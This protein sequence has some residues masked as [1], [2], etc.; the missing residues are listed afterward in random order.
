MAVAA[1]GWTGD[2]RSRSLSLSLPP[3]YSFSTA[4]FATSLSYLL[5]EENLAFLPPFFTFGAPLYLNAVGLFDSFFLVANRLTVPR[6]KPRI[7]IPGT[8]NG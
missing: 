8:V 7:Q 1:I 6:R 5:T 2:T 4:I 3:F